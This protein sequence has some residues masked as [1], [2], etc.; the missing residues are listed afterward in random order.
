[1]AVKGT[2]DNSKLGPFVAGTVTDSSTCPDSCP[3]KIEKLLDGTTK[4]GPCYGHLGP[5]RIHWDN[6]DKKTAGQAWE[7]ALKSVR[8]LRKGTLGRF[9]QV[10][11]HPGENNKLDRN[12][13]NAWTNAIKG[14]TWWGYTHYD[15]VS[16]TPSARHNLSVI[17]EANKNN[18]RLNVSC[19]NYKQV[20]KAIS[21]GLSAVVIVPS[22]TT[23]TQTTP[24]GHKVVMCPA[25]VQENVTC[26]GSPTTKACGGGT[27]LCILMNRKFAVGFPSHGSRKKSVDAL[28]KKLELFRSVGAK[29]PNL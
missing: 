10:G 15:A 13:M 8:R 6:L 9:G 5:I 21:L 17:K 1:M 28:L 7:D 25:A 19:E 24:G 22:D 11:D 2:T 18:Y 16:K 12:S 4:P 20:D 29:T 26:G 14:Q 27:P 3:L 23:T